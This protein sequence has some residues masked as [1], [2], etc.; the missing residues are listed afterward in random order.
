MVFVFSGILLRRSRVNRGG[1][2]VR[3]TGPPGLAVA[4]RVARRRLGAR[5]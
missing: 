4:G 1:R 5:Q 2:D 3:P